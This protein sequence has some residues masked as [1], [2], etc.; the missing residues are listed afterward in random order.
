MKRHDTEFAYFQSCLAKME[1]QKKKDTEA[2]RKQ[3]EIAKKEK[4]K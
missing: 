3:K 2:W 1:Y 4:K